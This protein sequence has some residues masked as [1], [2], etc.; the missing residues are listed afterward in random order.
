MGNVDN[1]GFTNLHV[2]FKETLHTPHRCV[3]KS[4]TCFNIEKQTNMAVVHGMRRGG[5]LD[6]I[7]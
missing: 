7:F 2:C 1:V 3:F 6:M 5:C 4:F